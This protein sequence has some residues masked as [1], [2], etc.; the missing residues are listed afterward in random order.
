LIHALAVSRAHDWR[1]TIVGSLSVDSPT[2]ADIRALIGRENLADSIHLMGELDHARLQAEY[3]RADIFVLASEFEG[4]GMAFAEAMAHGLP[5]VGSG[6]GAVAD[7]VPEDCGLLAPVGDAA[8]LSDALDRVMTDAPFR[9][10]LAAG[11]ARAGRRLPSWDAAAAEFDAA[12]ES[13][14]RALPVTA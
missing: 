11:A 1:L 5:I 6:G 12:L 4:Y 3:R 9:R 7:T 10:R 13:A 2:T 14:F 8:A